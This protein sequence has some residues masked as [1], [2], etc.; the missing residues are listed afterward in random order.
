MMGVSAIESR[1]N[2]SGLFLPVR[3]V[4]DIVDWG[5]Q[6]RDSTEERAPI[7]GPVWDHS[8]VLIRERTD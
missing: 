8:R 6:N 3:L 5:P 2:L 1:L 4:F 7:V